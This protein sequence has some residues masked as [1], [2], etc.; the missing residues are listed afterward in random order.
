MKHFQYLTLLIGLTLMGCATSNSNDSDINQHESKPSS[1]KG[2]GLPSPEVVM[3]ESSIDIPFELDKN[4]PAPVVMVE[5][6]GK[7]PYK[8]VVDTGAS[9]SILIRKS[10]VDG[11]DVPTIG[12]AMVGDASQKNPQKVPLVLIESARVGDL[13]LSNIMTIAMEPSVDHAAS[14]PDYLDGILGMELFADLLL[15][16]DYPENIIRVQKPGAAHLNEH[17][18]I[19]YNYDNSAIEIPVRIADQTFPILVDSG[20]RGTITLP[21]SLSEVLPL[22]EALVEIGKTAT[23]TNTYTREQSRFETVVGIAG[24][25][26]LNPPVVFADEHTPK[27]LG[28]GVLQHFAITIDQQSRRIQFARE[29]KAPIANVILHG[30]GI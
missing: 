27:L 18:S 11:L 10:V 25:E 1:Q 20:H 6:M 28:N 21:K 30:E 2:H 17:N 4:F 26:L 9:G 16:L 24:Y 23:V 5:I 14:I 3:D 29:S 19:V 22:S 13:Q 12:Y 15:T 7:G 8:F